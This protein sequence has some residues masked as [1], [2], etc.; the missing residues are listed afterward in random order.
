MAFDRIEEVP[1]LGLEAFRDGDRY[2]LGRPE[3]ALE[4][5]SPDNGLGRVRVRSGEER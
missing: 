5:R 4:G 1:G 2:R 3:W